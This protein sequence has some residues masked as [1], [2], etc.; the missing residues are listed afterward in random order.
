VYSA[1]RF[2]PLHR[3]HHRAHCIKVGA[4]WDLRPINQKWIFFY[5]CTIFA[6]SSGSENEAANLFVAS[7]MIIVLIDR[8]WRDDSNGGH[9][10]FWS[11]LDL[12]LNVQIVLR[13]QMQCW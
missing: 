10:V 2:Y 13:M 6:S 1:K 9:I 8:D 11:N 3:T 12:Y 4:F 5:T 7:I